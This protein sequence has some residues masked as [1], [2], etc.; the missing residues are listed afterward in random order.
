V[1][2]RVKEIP[3]L[4]TEFVELSKGY[5]R[6][7]I[8]VPAKKLGRLAG[9]GM[10][11]GFVFFLAAVLLAIAGT[12]AIVALMPDGQIWTGFGYIISAIGLLMVTGLVMWRASK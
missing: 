3:E 11:A 7:Q 9:F 6:D 12:R 4:V 8:T 10:A 2:S 5:V 1:T